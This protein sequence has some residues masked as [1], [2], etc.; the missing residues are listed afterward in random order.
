MERIADQEME[1]IGI[2]QSSTKENTAFSAAESDATT[3]VP[4]KVNQGTQMEPDSFLSVT[5]PTTQQS[6]N[7]P[8]QAS[9]HLPVIPSSPSSLCVPGQLVQG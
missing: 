4:S 7:L 1:T 5:H 9:N 3:S 2:R 6:Q 8:T